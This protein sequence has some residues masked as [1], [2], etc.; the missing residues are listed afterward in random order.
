MEE[1][2]I[3]GRRIKQTY[4]GRQVIIWLNLILVATLKALIDTKIYFHCKRQYI[5]GKAH[6]YSL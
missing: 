2:L 1:L 5:F 3:M 6:I 4:K